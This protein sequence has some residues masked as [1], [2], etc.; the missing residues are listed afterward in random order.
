ME[1]MRLCH[2][3]LHLAD[4]PRDHWKIGRP[5]GGRSVPFVVLPCVD[6]EWGGGAKDARKVLHSAVRGV[7]SVGYCSSDFTV[8]CR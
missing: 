1:D 3:P 7:S 4:K 5:L 2:S 6:F 8:T